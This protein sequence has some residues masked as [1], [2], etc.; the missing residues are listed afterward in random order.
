MA[1]RGRAGAALSI[2]AI[3]SF[4]AGTVA[5]FLL[6]AFA[7]E[8]FAKFLRRFRK[9]LGKVEKAMGLLLILTGIGFLTGSMSVFSFW[10]I[11]TFPALG[12]L[13]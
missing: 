9:H 10:L 11:E 2:A 1:R 3:G 4:F 8:H 13:G 6:A 12:R 7:V 5:T